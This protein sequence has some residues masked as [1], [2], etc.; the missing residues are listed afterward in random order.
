MASTSATKITHASPSHGGQL[1]HPDG[2]TLVV[3]GYAYNTARNPE[4]ATISAF[5]QQ[6]ASKGGELDGPIIPSSW[7]VEIAQEGTTL[8]NAPEWSFAF[9]GVEADKSYRLT[10]CA[11]TRTHGVG[12]STIWF[13]L[14]KA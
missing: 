8:D 2:A 14:K 4:Q 1:T 9:P 10:V 7:T 5:L 3:T 11:S 6:A 13:H 12:S